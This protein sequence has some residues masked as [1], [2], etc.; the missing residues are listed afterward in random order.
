VNA[1]AAEDVHIQYTS[2]Q[3][4]QQFLAQL[5]YAASMAVVRNPHR[6]RR[7]L[8]A[9]RHVDTVDNTSTPVIEN[10][11]E[12]TR[13]PSPTMAAAVASCRKQR[14]QDVV[15]S[16]MDDAEP[17]PVQIDGRLGKHKRSGSVAIHVQIVSSEA[18][19]DTVAYQRHL[20]SIRRG[21]SA[22]NLCCFRAGWYDDTLPLFVCSGRRR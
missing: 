10:F 19:A 17:I 11:H 5:R 3:E 16:S 15:S 9:L 14:H 18:F 12:E 7:A 1:A 13:P 21:I 20:V 2:A 6:F 22:L 8:A 4:R